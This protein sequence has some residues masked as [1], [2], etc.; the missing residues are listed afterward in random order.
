MKQPSFFWI[1]EAPLDYCYSDTVYSM[2]ADTPGAVL[3]WAICRV[4]QTDGSICGLFEGTEGYPTA[5][6]HARFITADL[7][8][9]FYSHSFRA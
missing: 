2:H 7:F 6:A 1:S 8:N 9:C 5:S 3:H 4:V